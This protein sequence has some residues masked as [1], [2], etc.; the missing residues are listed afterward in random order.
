MQTATRRTLSG[1]AEVRGIGLHGGRPARVRLLPAEPGAGIAF[2]RTDGGATPVRAVVDHVTSTDRGITLGSGDSAIRTVEHVLAAAQ[3]LAIDDLLVEVDG[4]ELPIGDGS[5]EPYREAMAGVGFTEREGP[6]PVTWTVSAALTVRE[7]DARYIVGPAPALRLTATIEWEHP[8]IGR[9]S[10][11]V[12]PS[13]ASFATDLARARTFG[14]VTEHDALKAKGLALGAS[15]ETVIGLTDTGLATGEL[16]WPDEFV[17]HK[18]VDLLGDLAL[19]GGRVVAEIVA[20]RPSHA[21]NVAL[22]KVLRR[23]AAP[24]AP[25]I[26]GVDEILGTLPHRYPLLLVDRILEVQ[27]TE[28]LVGIKNVTFNEPFFQGHF[29]GHPVMPG[30]LIIEAMAQ[31]GG[32][33]LMGSVDDPQTKV[34]Y[35]MSL[36]GVKFRRPV[37]PGDQLRFELEMLQFRGRNC[38]MRGVAYVDGQPVAEAEMAARIID[39]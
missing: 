39:R 13:E 32:M 35:F 14:F 20:F 4:D 33:L 11:C 24:K 38:R 29:P 19:T 7:G 30:V 23:L 17:R 3:A 26:L 27:G 5:A 36:D 18:L 22:A 9:Q 34:V 15:A 31:A 28:R 37:V 21:G 12:D 10:R 1:P 8:L 2:R 16:R 25:T 6:V